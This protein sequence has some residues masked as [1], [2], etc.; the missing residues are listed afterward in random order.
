MGN[1]GKQLALIQRDMTLQGRHAF[2]SIRISM[3][4]LMGTSSQRQ[5]TWKVE[6]ESHQKGA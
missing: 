2:P 5:G 3:F 4:S 1:V 6:L